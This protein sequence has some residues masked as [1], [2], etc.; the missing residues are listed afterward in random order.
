MVGS[1]VSLLSS[2]VHNN[3]GRYEQVF[4][5]LTLSF[6]QEIKELI[7]KLMYIPGAAFPPKHG[8]PNSSKTWIKNIP[9]SWSQ[10]N[11][12]IDREAITV[13]HLIH[14]QW[15]SM[16]LGVFFKSIS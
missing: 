16:F 2:I 13:F 4:C 7:E 14:S 9:I 10:H 12:E 5:C 3:G 8:I 11:A 15:N 1:K 6:K